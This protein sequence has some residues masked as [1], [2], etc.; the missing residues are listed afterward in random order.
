MTKSQFLTDY[1]AALIARCDWALDPARLER[2]M[3]SVER[4]VRTESAPWNHHSDIALSVLRAVGFK[5]KLTLK[6][7]RALP[8]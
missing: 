5:G 1:R 3:Q 2:F 4:T 8:N 6:A 7:L